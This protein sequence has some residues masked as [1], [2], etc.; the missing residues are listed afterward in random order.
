MQSQSQFNFDVNMSFLCNIVMKVKNFCLMTLEEALNDDSLATAKFI[1]E[2]TA[3]SRLDSWTCQ[4]IS[5]SATSQ[6][7][8][9]QSE[10]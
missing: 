9:Q 7:V 6:S 5:Q 3:W 2:R 4:L 1:T 10:Q 8:S